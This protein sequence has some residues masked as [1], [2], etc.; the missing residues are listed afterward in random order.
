MAA[1][2]WL[3]S[4]LRPA[5][6]DATRIY[7]LWVFMLWI[8]AA[9]LLVVIGALLYGTFRRRRSRPDSDQQHTR[10]RRMTRAVATG[11]G[12]TV[13]IL[14]AFLV[15]DFSVGRALGAPRRSG[16]EIELV[17]HRW[18]WEV[19]YL[20]PALPARVTTA[21]EIHIP[22]GAPVL[23]RLKSNDVIHSLW[24]P[25]LTG[26]RDLI[27]GKRTSLWLQADTP[28]VYRGQCAEFCGQQHAKMAL[29]VVADTRAGFDQWYASQLAPSAVP[30]DS[31]TMQGRQVFLTYACALCHTVRGT[32]AAASL[33][34]DLTH[35]A[36]R[37]TIGAGALDNNRGNLAG[38]I[39][40]AQ[41]IKP[42]VD[43]PPNHLEP[44]EAQALLAY[45]ETL[46]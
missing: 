39:L 19:R 37:R 14:F 16:F 44:D 42:G 28:G 29:L 45:L 10:Q 17:G 26:K 15:F 27:P 46:K 43:M 31:V 33:G 23:V 5:G 30:T 9:V 41:S 11:A 22:A 4:A 40:D 2:G 36:S 25:D 3:Q 34:P 38:W 8:S 1:A 32:P 20:A 24:V 18:W 13:V 7:G 6:P 21:N 35:L 12:V